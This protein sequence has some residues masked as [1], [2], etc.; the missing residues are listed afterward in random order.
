MHSPLA[1]FMFSMQFYFLLVLFFC[2]V[3]LTDSTSGCTELQSPEKYSNSAMCTWRAGK[4]C[5]HVLSLIKT[6][7][8]QMFLLSIPPKS[9]WIKTVNVDRGSALFANRAL[10]CC[11]FI[12]RGSL[13]YTCVALLHWTGFLTYE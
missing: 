8:H 2:F 5:I 12:L 6:P 3:F 10:T 9:I 13:I 1:A 7:T 4:E 11:S